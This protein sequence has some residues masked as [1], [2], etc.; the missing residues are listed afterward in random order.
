M[1][2]WRGYGILVVVFTAVGYALGK[3]GAEKIWGVPLPAAHRAGSELFGM[4]VA[5]AMVYGLHLAI[6]SKN[7]PRVLVDRET[8][9]EVEFKKK[10][11]LFFIPVKFWPYA[12]ALLGVLFYFQK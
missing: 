11:D 7:K 3:I 12:L 2:V 4:L 10:H 8:G 9:Q 1:L 6:E 5:A